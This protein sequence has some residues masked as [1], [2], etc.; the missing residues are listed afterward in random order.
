MAAN[1]YR[2]NPNRKTLDKRFGVGGYSV[3][4]KGKGK[5]RRWIVSRKAGAGGG[6]TTPTPPENKDPYGIA[7][8]A[9]PIHEQIDRQSASHQQWGKDVR[10]FTEKSL[11][12]I[13]NARQ[14]TNNAYNERLKGIAVQAAGSNAPLVSGSGGG[15]VSD[16][17][18]ALSTARNTAQVE[19]DKAQQS[20]AALNTSLDEKTQQEY[21]ASHLKGY[22]YWQSQLPAMY[23][24]AKQKY[25]DKLTEA[26]MDLE[27][28]KEVASIGADARMYSAQQQLMASLASTQGADNR[29]LM[30][31]ITSMYGVDQNNATRVQTT[32][33]N[34]DTQR[35]IQASRE[36]ISWAQLK[37][38]ATEAS[39]KGSLDM[40][41]FGQKTWLSFF[42]G[43]PVEYGDTGVELFI[44][45][46]PPHNLLEGATKAG[47]SLLR[48]T[49]VAQQV[50]G[51][52]SWLN[53]ATTQLGWSKKQAGQFLYN[54]IG[55][56]KKRRG[57]VLRR[58][59]IY[60][61]WN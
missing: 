36:K 7:A 19:M 28:K 12:T 52:K 17:N 21:I 53:I 40:K 27:G 51:A 24:E 48:S 35:D 4:V 57:Q 14:H 45:P 5:Q 33:M 2:I 39:G 10:G 32:G 56:N 38:K 61:G 37:Q 18:Q 60:L 3:K 46:N 42:N 13:Y 58:A 29:A 54:Y 30:Q 20:L 11:Q 6:N 9:K 15:T 50:N 47:S 41:K 23:N 1:T 34:N 16:P 8:A 44:N 43:T 31:S 59:G 49:N 55:G 25:T 22:D 26:V